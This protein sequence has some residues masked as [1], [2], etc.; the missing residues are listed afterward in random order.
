MLAEREVVVPT[1]DCASPTNLPRATAG[2][3]DNCPAGC[4]RRA[5]RHGRFYRASA[6]EPAGPHHALAEL[7]R[8]QMRSSEHLERTTSVVVIEA[9]APWPAFI[10]RQH[11]APDR[12]LLSQQLDETSAAFARRVVARLRALSS[13]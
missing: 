10:E 11:H 4:P 8:T 6:C 13:A 1:S 5:L 12:D 7:R 2:Q 9:G 3:A